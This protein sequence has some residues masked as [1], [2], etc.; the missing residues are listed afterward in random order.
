M[1]TLKETQKKKFLQ[2]GV[3]AAMVEGYEIQLAAKTRA[4]HAV[5]AGPAYAFIASED[6]C[7]VGELPRVKSG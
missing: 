1:K 7:P 5:L 4:P 2:V 3:W 6:L